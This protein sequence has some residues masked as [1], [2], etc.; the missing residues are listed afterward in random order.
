MTNKHQGGCLCGA[1]RYVATGP[2]RDVIFCHCAQ[3][4]KQTGLYYAATA[5]DKANLEIT[6][7][8]DLTWYS[9]SDFAQRG[10]CGTCGSALFWKPAAAPHIAILAGSLDDPSVLHAAYHICTKNRPAFYDLADGL[11]QHPHCAPGLAINK[12]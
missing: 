4:R 10:F 11:P 7:E 9:A 12:D 6:S 3:C 8:A 5:V 1:V 2:L